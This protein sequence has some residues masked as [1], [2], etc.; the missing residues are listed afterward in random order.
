MQPNTGP[1]AQALHAALT[2]LQRGDGDAARAAAEQ[3]LDGFSVGNDRTGAAAAHQILAMLAVA[4]GQLQVALSHI[5]AAIPLRENT[6]DYDGLA[7]LWQ[8]RFELCLRLGDDDGAAIAAEAQLSAMEK[9]GDREG[10]AHA[11]HQLAQVLLQTGNTERAEHLVQQALFDSAGPGL[12][13]ARA[14]LLLLYSTILMQRDD[15]DRALA[16]AKEALDLSRQAK[17][18]QSEVDALQHVGTAHALKGDLTMARRILEEALVGR[19][20]LK[21][22]EG[23]A[24]VLRELANVEF[25]LG[26]PDEAF[27]RLQSA[28]RGYHE[29]GNPIGEITM[30]QTILQAAEDHERPEFGVSASQQMIEAATRTGDREAVAAAHF[31]LATR[32]AGHGSLDEAAK[33]FRAAQDGQLALGLQHEAAVSAGMLG[34]VLV[35]AGQVDEGVALLKGSLLQLEALGSE[36]ADTVREILAELG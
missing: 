7:S 26:L 1:A 8:E 33:H 13:R 21:D 4:A 11:V 36:A 31:T 19:E 16:K 34:Q 10:M 20:L 2:A 14:A 15:L 28:V 29:Q 5:D 18:R 22:P 3:A 23:K 35:A 25:A 17:N 24:G 12:E 30:L 6:G 32:L 27:E 9:S